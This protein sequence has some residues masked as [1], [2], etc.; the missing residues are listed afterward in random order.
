M[1]DLVDFDCHFFT[2]GYSKI[3]LNEPPKKLS[4]LSAELPPVR[5]PKNQPLTYAGNIWKGYH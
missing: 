5:G 1:V 2:A 4:K 3:E